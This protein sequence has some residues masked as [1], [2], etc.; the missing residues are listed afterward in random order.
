MAE[1]RQLGFLRFSSAHCELSA[2]YAIPSKILTEQGWLY[3]HYHVLT[4]ERKS[5]QI[6]R[7]HS[8]IRLP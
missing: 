1:A 5:L 8:R 4:F 7:S 3:R 6:P 2:I